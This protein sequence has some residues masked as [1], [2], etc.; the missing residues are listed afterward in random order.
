[1][2]SR[3]PSSDH[4]SPA[5][6][7]D[8]AVV[9]NTP[10]T[11]S[12]AG[13][14]SFFAPSLLKDH[15]TLLAAAE[16][17]KSH[18]QSLPATENEASPITER[19]IKNERMV[20]QSAATSARQAKNESIS[21]INPL[22]YRCTDQEL[23]SIVAKL[24]SRLQQASEQATQNATYATLATQKQPVQVAAKSA[25]LHAADARL[26]LAE[27]RQLEPQRSEKS[28]KKSEADL[29]KAEAD[30]Q[31]ASQELTSLLKI[32]SSSFEAMTDSDNSSVSEDDE[33]DDFG[34]GTWKDVSDEEA[35]RR[36][37]ADKMSIEDSRM[38]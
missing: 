28:S 20:A 18:F 32:K 22:R 11:K 14:R 21:V 15:A 33:Q 4:F 5:T 23:L 26:A 37:E 17:A 2:S 30:Y 12:A 36:V 38:N 34:N 9:E 27:L 29:K 16:K 35:L 25:L 10:S 24:E 19:I 1:M 3:I 7:S 13:L 6:L 31:K 8:S